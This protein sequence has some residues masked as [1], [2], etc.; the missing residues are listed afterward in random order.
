MKI[1]WQ[2]VDQAKKAGT[3]GYLS[4]PG[5]PVTQL[6]NFGASREFLSRR[7]QLKTFFS[8]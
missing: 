1:D 5:R 2:R 4:V 3:N 8:L 7:F 6:V